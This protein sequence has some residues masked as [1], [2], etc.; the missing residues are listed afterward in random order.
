MAHFEQ[1]RHVELVAGANQL[2][3]IT[4]RMIDALIP[5][6]LPHLNIFVIT[7]N[8]VDDAKQDTLARIATIADLTVIP[9]GRDQGI[10][11]PGPDGIQFL[12]SAWTQTYEDLQ[13]ALDGA[14]VF[15]DR[16]NKLITDWNSFDTSFNAPDPA[17]A[18]Y[19][20]PTTDTS[21]KT[22]LIAAYKTA[23]QDRYQKQID[24]TNA[25]AALA[26][27]QSDYTYKQ[28]L[29]SGL[30][31]I[32]SLAT[33]VSSEM[34]TLSGYFS[35]LKAAGTTFAGNNPGGTG[36]AAF[37]AAL[38]AAA[39]QSAQATAYVADAASLAALISSY[40]TARATDVTTAATTVATATADQATK[41][42]ALTSAQAT[43]AT[44]LAAVL[45]VCPDFDKH[46][47]PFVDDTEP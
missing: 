35:T 24:K 22:Q 40:Q 19:T 21:Q 45:A 10:A 2:F 36:I 13:T 38:N 1:E 39:S 25:D 28:S 26:R 46:S 18:L 14:Q 47:I 43:E 9:I 15:R 20:F 11:A 8:A 17:P 34:S 44:A 42:Q 5:T 30:T 16:V 6:Q 23:K 4:N 29:V 37:Q 31:P 33:Q 41:A 7:V 12:S 32:S 3:S 27:A